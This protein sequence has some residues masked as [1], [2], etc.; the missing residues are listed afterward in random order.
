MLQVRHQTAFAQHADAL[1]TADVLAFD[2]I[3]HLHLTGITLGISPVVRAASL[4]LLKAAVAAGVSVSFDPNLRLNLWPDRQEMRAVIN[5]VAARAAVVMPGVGEARLLAGHDDPE[6]IAKSYLD[7]G[8]REVVIKLGC[9]GR[10][11]LDR[12]RSDCSVP[13]VL[14][15]HRST[16][17]A[18]AT[19]SQPAISRLSSPAPAC[20]KELIK[21]PQPAPWPP[22]D[23]ATW[24]P[25]RTARKSTPCSTPPSK[26]R[27]MNQHTRTAATRRR[28]RQT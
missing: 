10:P 12:R 26:E 20:K 11:R 21:V 27:D 15:S 19:A 22:P 7:A 1:L 13:A 2:G 23:G 25:C 9:G 24:P 28:A 17:L 3:D 4:T 16:P 8:P 6:A 18:L 14:P 5:T